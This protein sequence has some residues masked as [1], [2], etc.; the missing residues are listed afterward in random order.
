MICSAAACDSL[1]FW[2]KPTGQEYLPVAGAASAEEDEGTK[3]RMA[4]GGGAGPV[5]A[6]FALAASASAAS[7]SYNMMLDMNANKFFWKRP[8]CEKPCGMADHILLQVQVDGIRD[9]QLAFR[10]EL[11]ECLA[12]SALLQYRFLM[13]TRIPEVYSLRFG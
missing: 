10:K 12:I 6:A 13:G 4:V 5:A 11:L 9:D 1:R 3:P 2:K 8:I 7:A